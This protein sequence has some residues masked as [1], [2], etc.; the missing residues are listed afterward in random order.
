MKEYEKESIEELRNEDY[1]ASGGLFGSSIA[2]VGAALCVEPKCK[3]SPDAL[4]KLYRSAV[5]DSQCKT[6]D[7][8]KSQ[9][10]RMK[11]SSNES[12]SDTEAALS[13]NVVPPPSKNIS[14]MKFFETFTDDIDRMTDR[15]FTELKYLF[16]KMVFEFSEKENEN[17]TKC[18]K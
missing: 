10:K 8:Q 4:G 2:K 16:S 13:N 6:S 5:A 7:N 9:G 14:R 17:T 3:Q 15:S 12:S 18:K 11:F 1:L